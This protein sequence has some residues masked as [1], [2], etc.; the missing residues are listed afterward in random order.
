MDAKFERMQQWKAGL[1]ALIILIALCLMVPVAGSWADWYNEMN[2]DHSTAT[3]IFEALDTHDSTSGYDMD[4]TTA[5]RFASGSFDEP[6]SYYYFYNSSTTV[7]ALNKCNV[8]A[9]TAGVPTVTSTSTSDNNISNVPTDN[10]WPYWIIVFD[11]RAYDA[12]Y[13]NVVRIKLNVTT[14]NTGT[15]TTTLGDWT[16]EVK[17]Y[18]G[19]TDH[20]IYSTTLG[21]ADDEVSENID[22]DT[23]DIRKAI[24]EYGNTEGFLTL[25][26]TRAD[27]T[28]SLNGCSVYVYSA[29]NLVPRDD[30][31]GVGVM[32]A[33]VIGFVGAIIVQPSISISNILSRGPK[34]KGRGR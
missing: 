4:G 32:A 20:L 5:L 2:S 29:T 21:Q 15:Y 9:L 23:N 18:W 26:I 31:L 10:G 6:K 11:Y 34:G 28:I 14:L 22:L 3:S 8:T 33:G 17:L 7:D 30:G 13:D 27:S 16:Q 19:S 12:Y 1:A 24:I 25:K